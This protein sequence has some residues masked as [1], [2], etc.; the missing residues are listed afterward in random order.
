MVSSDVYK[1]LVGGSRTFDYENCCRILCRVDTAVHGIFYSSLQEITCHMGSHCVTC[2]PAAV[3]FPLL[4]QQKLVLD[5]ATT[6]GCKAELTGVVVI[7]RNRSHT[8]YCHLFQKQVAQLWQRDCMKLVVDFLFT[9]IEH[10][11]VAVTV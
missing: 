1:A 8:K 10:F 9:I 11:S 3:T 2:H 5:L 7:S 4:P 6:E